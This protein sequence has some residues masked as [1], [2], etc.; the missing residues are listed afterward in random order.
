MAHQQTRHSTTAALLAPSAANVG[1]RFATT[2]DLPRLTSLFDAYRVFYGLAPNP[3]AA[4]Q[5]LSTRLARDESVIL[6]GTI[7]D[8]V[9]GFAQLFRT[10]SSLSLGS[11]IVLNDL[12]VDPSARRRGIGGRLVDSAV[13]Y[14]KQWGAIRLDLEAHPDNAP[15]LELYR[16]KGFVPSAEFA[17]LSRSV[18]SS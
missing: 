1:I 13:E 3:P 10:F 9:V 14:A 6:V 8:D 11:V 12:Y 4:A 15:A 5:F 16:E 17:H 18:R 2:R 7:H